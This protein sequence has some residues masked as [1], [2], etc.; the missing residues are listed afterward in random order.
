MFE[1]IE[2]LTRQ[3]ANPREFFN[4]VRDEGWKPPFLFF[5][6]VTL[7]ISV[8]TPVL[9]Y[10]GMESTDFSSSYQAQIVAYNLLK[11]S[12][13]RSY[14]AHAY[15]IE[16]VLIF[17]FAV[18]ILLL[19]TS[20]SHL[21]YRLIGGQGSILNAWKAACYGVGPCLLGGFLPYVS[22]FAAFYSFTMQLYLGPM[23]LYRAKEGRAIVVF[24][25][26]IALTFIEMFVSG[27]TVGF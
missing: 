12:L 25:A 6:W 23:T 14:G 8:V 16:A 10:F 1:I 15:L 7:L 27:T 26:L 3:L 18:L 11:K 5:L 2:K 17:A 9:N 19:L 21:V 20:F 22:L 13:F 4:S 24:V